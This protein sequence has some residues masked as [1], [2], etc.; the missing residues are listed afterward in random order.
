MD[1]VYSWDFSKVRD[2]YTKRSGDSPSRSQ[3][4]ELEP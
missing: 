3:S 4:E 1:R 2:H